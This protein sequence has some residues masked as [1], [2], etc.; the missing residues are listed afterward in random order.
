MFQAVITG[1]DREAFRRITFMLLKLRGLPTTE[2]AKA[3]SR[4]RPLGRSQSAA[5]RSG[6]GPGGQS[7]RRP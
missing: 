1:Y 7:D 5:R 4:R 6:S 2:S 3:L